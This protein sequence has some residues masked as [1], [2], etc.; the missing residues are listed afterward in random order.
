LQFTLQINLYILNVK[1]GIHA[2]RESTR[3]SHENDPFILLK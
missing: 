2:Y 3:S 1:K